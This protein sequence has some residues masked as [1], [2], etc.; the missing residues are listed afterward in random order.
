[1]IL[2]LQ[3]ARK[4]HKCYECGRRIPKGVKYWVKLPRSGMRVLWKEHTNCVEFEHEP[5]V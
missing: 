5:V 1:M 3:K 4:D 2:R